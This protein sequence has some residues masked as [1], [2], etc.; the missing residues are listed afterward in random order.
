MTDKEQWSW[1]CESDEDHEDA[2][3]AR[4]EAG[5]KGEGDAAGLDI[6]T[7]EG[8]G[9][10]GYETNKGCAD[11]RAYMKDATD[12]LPPARAWPEYERARK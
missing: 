2:A 5:E 6:E 10:L 12:A 11:G 8:A 4:E 1:K 3:E 7:G 9:G